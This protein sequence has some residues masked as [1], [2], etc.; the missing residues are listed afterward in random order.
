MTRSFIATAHFDLSAGLRLH[1]LGPF[2]VL[3]L[4]LQ[5]PARI[6]ALFTSQPEPS[7]TWQRL[8][9]L[10]FEVL[11]IS[12]AVVGVWRIGVALFHAVGIL[13]SFSPPDT[14]S[15]ALA[16][17]LVSAVLRWAVCLRRRSFFVG[18]R[19]AEQGASA[20]IEQ[21]AATLCAVQRG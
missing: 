14:F 13:S 17:I 18:T 8:C 10:P 20:D 4:V 1:P 7:R 21:R 12:L 11:A 9:S 3:L 6:V 15:K 16:A 19:T 2:L 5:I